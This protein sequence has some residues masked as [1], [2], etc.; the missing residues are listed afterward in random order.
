MKQE[1]VMRWGGRFG[2]I[3]RQQHAIW[4]HVEDCAHAQRTSIERSNILNV[5]MESK[6]H[7]TSSSAS[8][9]RVSLDLLQTIAASCLH[10]EMF[11]C[12]RCIFEHMQSAA[13]GTESAKIV[14]IN[15][16]TVIKI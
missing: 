6:V 8:V 7:L 3:S 13:R 9:R 5:N 11:K 15:S 12:H 1:S 16:T 4:K 14:M 10:M 2:V